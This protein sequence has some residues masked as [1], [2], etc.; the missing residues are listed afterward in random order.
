MKQSRKISFL[1][2]DSELSAKICRVMM[3]YNNLR[4]TF[5]VL[6]QEIID[7]SNRKKSYMFLIQCL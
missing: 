5:A 2:I 4:L 6:N 7:I 1:I 3:L